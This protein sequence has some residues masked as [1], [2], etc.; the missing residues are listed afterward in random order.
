M[1]L[2][3]RENHIR[4]K[5]YLK[6]FVPKRTDGKLINRLSF[7]YDLIRKVRKDLSWLFLVAE[8]KR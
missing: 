6:N 8:E 5:P 1:E 4:Q 2:S 7:F 3:V